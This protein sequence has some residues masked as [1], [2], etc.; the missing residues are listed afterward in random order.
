MIEK[1][2]RE[3]NATGAQPFAI[4]FNDPSLATADAAPRAV[5]TPALRFKVSG[6]PTLHLDRIVARIC[7]LNEQLNGDGGARVLSPQQLAAL[8]ALAVR[9]ADDIDLTT[10]QNSTVLGEQLS[11]ELWETLHV[12]LTRGPVS[13]L[14]FPALG[15]F[16]V[17]LLLPVKTPAILSVK[18]ECFDQVLLVTERD[19]HQLSDAHTIAL[20]SVLVNGFANPFASELVLARAVRVLP[21]AF[22]AIA[23]ARPEHVRV[24]GASLIS[25]CCLALQIEEEVVIT[26][27]ICGAVETLDRIARDHAVAEQQQQQTVAGV[28]A[29]VARLVRTF[30]AARSLSVELGLPDVLRRLSTNAQ[31]ES[32]QPLVRELETLM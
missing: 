28:V 15:V 7:A 29:G 3:M 19:D 32:V 31:L 6:A 23:D 18:T 8:K 9:V 13:P 2:Q 27:I 10:A 11:L 1:M 25:N 16:R 22:A 20:L 4:P 17:L 5:E 21:F 14:F 26:T 12:L 24:L 30:Q